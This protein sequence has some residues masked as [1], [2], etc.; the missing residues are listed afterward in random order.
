MGCVTPPLARG[1]HEVGSR[2]LVGP[3]FF[4]IPVGTFAI[5]MGHRMMGT[6]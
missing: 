5:G 4:T 2:S 3:A 6:T 1:S